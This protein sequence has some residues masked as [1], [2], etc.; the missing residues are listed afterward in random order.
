MINFTTRW[1]TNTGYPMSSYEL[2]KTNAE[3]RSIVER[4]GPTAATIA[5]N[6]VFTAKLDRF[7]D[8]YAQPNADTLYVNIDD[9][10][11]PYSQPMISGVTLNGTMVHTRLHDTPHLVDPAAQYVMVV[12]SLYSDEREEVWA[13]ASLHPE[14]GRTSFFENVV[15]A[16]ELV[17]H[18]P[19]L[20][21][22]GPAEEYDDIDP[23][24]LMLQQE[25]VMRST[26]EVRTGQ[27][28]WRYRVDVESYETLHDIF[29]ARHKVAAIHQLLAKQAVRQT[30]RSAAYELQPTGSDE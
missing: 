5:L 13:A 2:P 6:Q 14:I 15:E 28:G 8:L 19:G 20:R 11:E 25:L 3:M 21:A 22:V 24:D 18:G 4:F 27:G 23:Q 30:V 16:T 26:P 9:K 12:D 29:Q 1:N 17:G 7:I 10:E